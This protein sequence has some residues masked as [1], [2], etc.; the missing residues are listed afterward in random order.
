MFENSRPQLFGS[1][2]M[3]VY[4][5]PDP[6]A[7]AIQQALFLYRRARIAGRLSIFWAKIR[8]AP[9]HLLDLKNI[10]RF[11]V[12]ANAHYLGTHSVP[13]HKIYGSEGRCQDFTRAFH[14][15]ANHNRSRWLHIATLRL[16]NETLPPIE[17]IQIEDR[18]FVRDGHHR[19]S[20]SRAL[21]Q[22]HVDALLTLWHM[23]DPV[24]WQ[25]LEAECGMWVYPV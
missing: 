14:P 9:F 4:K 3:P 12:I 16:L 1:Q 19:T 10:L 23:Q 2:H 7:Y 13:I 22:T 8:H 15:L 21:G 11:C 24:P 25:P 5:P 17:L 20:V 6:N 18:C